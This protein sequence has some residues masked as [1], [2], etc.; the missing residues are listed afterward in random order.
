MSDS[1]LNKVQ[2]D[3]PLNDALLKTAESLA[4]KSESLLNAADLEKANNELASHLSVYDVPDITPASEH[5]EYPNGIPPYE[6]QAQ[7]VFNNYMNNANRLMS[8]KEK[9]RLFRECLRNAKKGKYEYMFDKEKIAKKEERMR[10]NFEKLNK[11]Q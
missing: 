8:G 3:L 7:I 11:P 6:I 2:E 10:K 1:L 9:R 4:E 5:E